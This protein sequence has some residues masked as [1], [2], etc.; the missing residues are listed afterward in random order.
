MYKLKQKKI[1]MASAAIFVLT[2]DNKKKRSK[3]VKDWKLNRHKFS[4]N[5]LLRELEENN[6]DDYKNYLRMDSFSIRYTK[7]VKASKYKNV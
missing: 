5:T 1:A 6:P 2:K 3:W 7:N 4:D